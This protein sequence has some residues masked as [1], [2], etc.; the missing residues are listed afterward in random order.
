M[1][2]IVFIFQIIFEFLVMLASESAKEKFFSK[3]Q[4]FVLEFLAYCIGGIFFGLL[5]L[6]LFTYSFI[7]ENYRLLNM[8]ITSILLGWLM[9]WICRRRAAKGQPVV[10]L[11]QFIYGFSFAL[12]MGLVRYFFAT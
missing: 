3:K 9:V 5:S 4:R 1:E 6:L 7:D 8:I 2:I 11:H 10:L 12:S